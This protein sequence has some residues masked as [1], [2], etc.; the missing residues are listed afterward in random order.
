[1]N[2]QRL[3]TA[4]V[5]PDGTFAAG[6]TGTWSVCHTVGDYGIDD[7]GSIAIARRAMCDSVLPQLDDPGTEGYV[8]VR[9]DSDGGAKFRA[10][11][12]NRWWIRPWRGCLVIHIYDGSLFPGDRVHVTFGDT[13]GGSPGW[14][15][16]TFPETLHTF[17]VLVDSAGSREYYE[18]AESPSITVVPA[19]PAGVDA[20]LP[21]VVRP[22]AD[23]TLRVR[24]MDR[25]G[26]PTGS[27]ACKLTVRCGDAVLAKKNV[28]LTCGMGAIEGLCFDDGVAGELAI[29]AVTPDGTF[30]GC[31]N[32]FTV[33][34]EKTQVF[35]ADLHGQTRQT[36]G[37]GTVEEYFRFARD[38]GLLDAAG[39]Q[40]NDF[41]VTDALWQDVCDQT[42]AFNAPGAF[43][44]F[45]GYEWSGTTPA[46]GDHNI[47]YR[48]DHQA[49]H[50][51]SHWQVHD[52]SDE[53]SDR[54]PISALWET[55]AGRD[56]VMA[57]GHVG[58]RFANFDYYDPAM[59][60]L[61]E[62]HSH[63]GTFEWFAMDA[64]ARGMR[65]GFVAQ[66]DDHSGRPGHSAPLGYLAPDFATFDVWGGLTG[67]C[68][69]A[70]DRDSLWEAMVRRHC[71]ATS[72]TRILMDVRAGSFGMGD[73]IRK[74]GD[75]DMTIAV[76]GTAGILDVE[77]YRDTTIIDRLRQPADAES[78][79]FAIQFSGVRIRSRAKKACWNG[80]LSL[81]RGQ[82]DAVEPFA[83]DCDQEGVS[84]SADG[85]TLE[86]ISTT[87][88]DIDGVCFTPK[89]GNATLRI[90]LGDLDTSV[91]L[92]TLTDVPLD[93]DA[94]GV[95]QTVRIRRV[96]VGE[97]PRSVAL[98][99]RIAA[100]APG[101]AWWVKVTQV[102]GHMAWASPMFIER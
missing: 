78:D 71:Y 83:F 90:A 56:D 13:T 85:K 46:G 80:T 97:R 31:S 45:L 39:W 84:L 68:A 1:M 64:L 54:C 43:V 8:T 11:Y 63:H 60:K 55:F 99:H 89:D 102:D 59:V 92:S 5:T 101:G 95:N 24:L 77:V 96:A 6:S 47:L 7:G 41:Q 38:K 9:I 100:D 19:D 81:D 66:S 14:R 29:E 57:I 10:F 74:P 27:G 3:G 25:F 72:G 36:V 2:Q 17:K 51:S 21:S 82:F 76:T 48:R 37:T 58:G 52:G 4:R 67:I 20:I 86:V 35:W 70:L 79:R 53:S 28:A 93:I 49:I 50:R 69:D 30:E 75:L 33:S 15:L 73:C 40:G 32:P 23:T 61:V 26:N 42:A 88:G 12:D 65:V 87:A 62:I 98:T 18:I 91:D 22:G 94:G 16:Q 34:N 44:T